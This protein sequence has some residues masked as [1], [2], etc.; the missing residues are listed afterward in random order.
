MHAFGTKSCVIFQRE[1]LMEWHFMY[2]HKYADMIE[3]NVM[4][5]TVFQRFIIF[6][7]SWSSVSLVSSCKYVECPNIVEKSIMFFLMSIKYHTE[8]V[9]LGGATHSRHK[10]LIL[11][12]VD[13]TIF[14]L[15]LMKSK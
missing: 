14:I 2:C 7:V 1:N 4:G 3:A 6:S 5:N 9:C 11:Y 15:R 10:D 8:L 12:S 13:Y